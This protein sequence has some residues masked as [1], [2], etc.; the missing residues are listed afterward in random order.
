[1][2]RKI[3]FGTVLSWGGWFLFGIIILGGLAAAGYYVISTRPSGSVAGDNYAYQL[4]F[5]HGLSLGDTYST[6]K[7]FVGKLEKAGFSLKHNMSEDDFE[8]DSPGKVYLFR[9]KTAK[10]R[11]TALY[12]YLNHGMP[13]P[14]NRVNFLGNSEDELVA[15]L[16]KPTYIVKQPV[17]R[18]VYEL[19]D[20]DLSVSF[21]A[22]GWVVET[23][24]QRP[25]RRS[26]T[27]PN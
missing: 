9:V 21:G 5:E 12:H 18:Y 11:I 13:R 27:P 7:E 17:L 1:V 4:Q 25:I 26:V 6:E 2:G 19:A 14:E 23:V 3:A 10:G 24:L 15:A 8:F 20:A 16:G 22:D